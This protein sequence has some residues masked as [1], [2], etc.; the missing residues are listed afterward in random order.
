VGVNPADEKILI[1]GITHIS[2]DVEEGDL[3]LGFAGANVHGA[4]FSDEAKNR[5]ARAVL[6][7]ME[8]A[9]YVTNMPVLVVVDPRSSAGTLSAWFY[10]E[11][12]RD[13]FSVGI[14]GTNGKTTT[15]Y[16]LHQIWQLDNR[17][18]GLIGTI[19]TRIGLES[20]PSKRT[21]PESCEL[22][23]L[24]AAMREQHINNLAMEVSSHALSLSRMKG[25][26]F[27]VA[28]FTNL[29]QDH[30]DFHHSMAEY[31]ESK[32]QLFTYEYSDKAIINLD[33][34]YGRQLVDKCEVPFIGTSLRNKKAD[35]H[36]TSFIPN[37]DGYEISIRGIGGILIESQLNLHGEHNLENALMAVAIAI[38]SGV[39]P[40]ALSSIIPLLR[41]ASG[42]LEPVELG[43]GFQALVDYA[44]SPDAVSRVLAAC[45]EFSLGKI[46]A[47]LGCGGDRDA[48]KRAA[49]GEALLKGSDIAIFTSDN[50]RS[51]SPLEILRQMTAGL[52]VE[53][54]SC[55]IEDR[56]EAIFYAVSLAEENDLVLILGKGH[57]TGQEI[58]GIVFPF[59]DRTVL[60]SAIE[61]VK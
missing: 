27:S 9:A 56:R 8:G 39:D 38:E 33:D 34:S 43:Q 14:T 29:T 32:S 16:L 28:A 7:D 31:F 61:G 37:R 41:T 54:P 57:E 18:N 36:Y 52:S 6:T 19:E 55:I 25:S 12:M 59:D 49:M 4:L 53:L 30:L 24:V 48:T 40:I 15:C 3:F 2:S 10:G 58:A 23:S 1:S 26:H 20:F 46:I 44:H 22:Q 60:A 42:R 13:L 11:P 47:V 51:E 5:G 17:E 45:R 50:P 21:T 35:W